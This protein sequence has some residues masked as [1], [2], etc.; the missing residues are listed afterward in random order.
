MGRFKAEKNPLVN[1]VFAKLQNRALVCFSLFSLFLLLR[2]VAPQLLHIS[3][4]HPHFRLN[5]NMHGDGPPP[6]PSLPLPSRLPFLQLAMGL[7]GGKPDQL[8]FS[9]PPSGLPYTKLKWILPFW[10]GELSTYPPVPTDLQYSET[11]TLGLL[12]DTCSQVIFQLPIST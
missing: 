12:P 11:R 3:F 9:P 10:G 6:S 7:T 4:L 8:S 2:A 1:I 5:R